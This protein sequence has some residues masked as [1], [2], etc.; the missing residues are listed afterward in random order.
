V[1]GRAGGGDLPAANIRT[2]P[3]PTGRHPDRADIDALFRPFYEAGQGARVGERLYIVAAGHGISD[4]IDLHSVALLTA[5]ATADDPLHVA[6]VKRAE[7]FRRHAAFDEIVLFADCCRDAPGLELALPGWPERWNAGR[8]HPRAS[9]VRYL[10]GFAAGYGKKARERDFGDG[11]IIAMPLLVE[12]EMDVVTAIV[13][14][15][16][17]VLTSTGP[18]LLW[19]GIVGGLTLAATVPAFVGL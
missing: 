13:T 15:W 9:R 14:S 5:D 16:K 6:M 19:G 2:L 17:T 3:A 8:A 10:H 1:A 11:R 12:R 7:W 18:M 4:G